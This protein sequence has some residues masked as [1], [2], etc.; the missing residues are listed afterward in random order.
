VVAVSVDS[1]CDAFNGLV[2]AGLE[3]TGAVG[4]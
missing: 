4:A 3:A 2:S 1:V